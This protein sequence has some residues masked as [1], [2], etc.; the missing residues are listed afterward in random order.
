MIFISEI[1]II[2]LERSTKFGKRRRSERYRLNARCGTTSAG[3]IAYVLKTAAVFAR[4]IRLNRFAAD[5]S[6]PNR[7]AHRDGQSLINPLY[8]RGGENIGKC[9]YDDSPR[10]RGKRSRVHYGMCNATITPLGRVCAHKRRAA[11]IVLLLPG[12]WR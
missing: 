8:R 2:F 9:F 6:F 11:S 7:E 5:Q 3:D 10:S 4:T 1:W 12:W